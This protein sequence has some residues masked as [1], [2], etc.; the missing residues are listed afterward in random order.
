MATRKQ[1]VERARDPD[2]T[3]DELVGAVLRLMPDAAL[4]VDAAGQIVAANPGAEAMFGYPP[5]ALQGVAVDVLVPERLRA[6]HARHRSSYMASSSQR[7]MGAAVELWAT[8]LDGTEFPVDI[9]LAPLGMPERALTLA[10]VRDL[11]GRRAEWD[12]QAR[13]A[14]IVSSTDDAIVSTDLNGTIT[15][16]NPGAQR[17][18]GY[19]AD[20]VI[21]R[22]VWRLVPEG[23][24][25]EVE[26]Q[27]ARARGGV[28]IPTRDTLRLDRHGGQ[29]EVAESLSLVR[30]PSGRP[31]GMSAVMR[32]ISV[33]K[34]AERELRRLLVDGQRRERW[35]GAI[36]EV[37]LSMLGGG[38]LDE[39]LAL[40]ARRVSE[41]ADADGITVSVVADDDTMLEVIAA[42]GAPVEEY[43]GDLVPLEGSLQ[44]RVFTSNRS[45]AID[46]PSAA[47]GIDQGLAASRGIGPIL[48]APIDTA[49]GVGGVLGVVRLAGNAPFSPEEIRVV[50]SF[51]Q[52]AGLAIELDRAQSDR[53]QLALIGDRERIARDLHDHVIQRLFAVGMSLQAATHSITDPA[54]LDRIGES[55]E[56]LDATIRDVRSTIFSLSLRATEKGEASARSR[57]LDVA[58]AAVPALGFQPRL[59]FDGPVDTKVSQELVPDVLAVVREALSNTA[60]HANATRVEVRVDAHDELSI[61]ITDD[62][63]GI[64]DTTRSSGLANLRTRAEARGGSMTVG[65]ADERGTRLRWRV[66]F[67]P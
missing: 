66:P 37:R 57:I 31:T 59:Q 3:P 41:L 65:P 22:P 30:D 52:Q 56:E 11:T 55:V 1:D 27:M 50:E 24:R 42:H 2:A 54:V 58:A 61:T 9:S 18:L 13:L 64:G 4:V 38:D 19:R 17:L 46:D 7:P 32:D 45:I 5:G 36:S 51:G 21:G 53:E 6:G 44:G 49:H 48:V 15:S 28:H 12:A 43:R 33:R 14:A 20:E 67:A 16:W 10:A 34:R 29:V 60:R 25:A 26:E 8:R 23:L 63:D 62:G 39:W 40:I 47:I 35:L